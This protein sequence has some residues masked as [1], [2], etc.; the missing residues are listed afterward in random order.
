MEDDS[1][2]YV[3]PNLKWVSIISIQFAQKMGAYSLK[4]FV[5]S[6]G[7]GITS[8]NEKGLLSY[9]VN[10]KLFQQ[11]SYLKIYNKLKKILLINIVSKIREKIEKR[12]L[13]YMHS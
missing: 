7:L 2:R 12:N 6:R 13:I 10:W 1:K 4:Q 9:L 8:W 5:N 3:E 11:A